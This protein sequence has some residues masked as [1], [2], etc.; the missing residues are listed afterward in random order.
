V[1]DLKLTAKFAGIEI[2]SVG[3]PKWVVIALVVV[4]LGTY[5]LLH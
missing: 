2:S 4:V 1:N 5:L 3:P